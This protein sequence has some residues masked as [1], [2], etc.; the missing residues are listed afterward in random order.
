MSHTD[1]GIFLDFL[2]L[3]TTSTLLRVS[4]GLVTAYILRGLYVGRHSS[5]REIALM[6]LA[7]YLSYMLVELFELSGILTVVFVG[8][9]MS[10]Y[11]WHNVTESS[12]N[13]KAQVT[14]FRKQI[15][16]LK[17]LKHVS[18]L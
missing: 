9:L 5:A 11:S 1:H 4:V 13:L 15:V 14:P 17:P 10:H 3:F 12:R 18:L 6:V 8:V 16:H 7:A 2:S